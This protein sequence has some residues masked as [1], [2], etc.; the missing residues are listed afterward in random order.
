[1]AKIKYDVVL[2]KVNLPISSGNHVE[3]IHPLDRASSAI[4]T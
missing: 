2:S 4:K 3:L 1:M